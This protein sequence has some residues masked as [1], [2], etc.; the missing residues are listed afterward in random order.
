LISAIT[1]T[2]LEKYG[3]KLLPW[4]ITELLFKMQPL[5]GHPPL[6]ILLNAV[7]IATKNKPGEP[8]TLIQNG[9]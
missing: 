4:E 7:V 1:I 5:L 2:L 9:N 8:Y 3:N 6:I